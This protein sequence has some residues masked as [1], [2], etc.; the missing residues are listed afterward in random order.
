LAFNLRAHAE[1]NVKNVRVFSDEVDVHLGPVTG[2]RSVKGD[3]GALVRT[4]RIS[5]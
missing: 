3:Q 1:A 2:P 5:A 4:A